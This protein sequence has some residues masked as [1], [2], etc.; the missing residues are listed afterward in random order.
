MVWRDYILKNWSPWKLPTIL[1]ILV[2]HHWW[3]VDIFLAFGITYVTS[4]QKKSTLCPQKTEWC[5][6]NHMFVYW[7]FSLQTN[8]DFDAKP[9]VMLLGQYSTGKTTFLKHL[10]KSS[11]P[12]FL[13]VPYFFIIF[14]IS[15]IEFL[16]FHVSFF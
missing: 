7:Y 10:L 4:L 13:K 1:M 12:G 15:C 11:Y 6:T 9:M 2:L 3:V 5:L 14:I 16:Y 8:S